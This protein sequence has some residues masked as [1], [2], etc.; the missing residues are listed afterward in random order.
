MGCIRNEI[1]EIRKDRRE[2]ARSEMSYGQ[3][4]VSYQGIASAMPSPERRVDR[5]YP[6]ADS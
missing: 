2:M 6:L 3:E 4:R 5:L 1:V